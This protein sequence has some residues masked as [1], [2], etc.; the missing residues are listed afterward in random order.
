MAEPTIPNGEE[1]FFPIIYEGNGA[2]Q[3]VGKFVPFTD[4]GTIA[5]SCIFNRAD[6]ATMSRTLETPTNGKIWTF[7]TWWKRGN[8]D[9]DAT[10][11]LG[12]SANNGGGYIGIASNQFYVTDL[13]YSGG[14]AVTLSVV[15]NRTLEDTS[16][17]Y[18]LM[19]AVDTT[20]STANDR[21]KIYIDGDRVTSLDT[22]T[23]PSADLITNWNGGSGT[24]YIGRRGYDT[25]NLLDGYMAET[26]FVD[27][28]ALT[29]STFGVTDTTTGRWIPKTL[30][31]ITYGNSGWRLTYA[32]A[33]N[34]GDD[35]SGNTNDF[36][37]SNLASTDQ[38]TSTPSS[39]YNTFGSFDTGTSATQGNLT[40]STGTTNGDTQCVAQAGFGVATGKWYWEVKITTVGAGMYGWKDD[41]NAGGSQAVNNSS[42]E[43]HSTNNFAG[44]LSTGASGG[45][46]A[47]SWFIDGGYTTEVNYTTVSTNDVLMFAMDLDNGKGYCGKNGTWFNSAN[48]ANGTGQIGGCHYANGVNKFYPMAR[49]VDPNSVGEFNFGQK[50]FAHTAPTGFSA[51]QQDNLPETAKGVSGLVWTKNRDAT[52]S[53]QLYDSSRGKQKVLTSD[54]TTAEATVVDGLQKFLKGGQQIEDDVSVNSEDESYVSWNWTANSGSTSTNDASATGVGTIDSTYQVNS[55]SGFSIVEHTGTGSAGTIK[56]G[57]SVKPAFIMTKSTSNDTGDGFTIYHQN[58]TSAAYYLNLAVSNAEASASTVWNST[59]PT[60]SVF[61]VGT[62]SG[63]NTNTYTYVSYCWAE[64]EGFSK[65]GKYSGNGNADGPFVYTGFRPAFLMIKRTDSSTGG[66]WSIIDN[67]K[68]PANPIGTPLLADSTGAES[69]LS[70]IT[71]DLLSNGFKI[72][73]TL[74]SNNNSSGSYIYMSF[75]E[76]P[77]VGDG[78]NPV[79]AR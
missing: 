55:T 40:V 33:S 72:R 65:F 64:V 41:A 19:V 26:N 14:W 74:N 2:G 6:S 48:P 71:M 45:Y 67:A 79:T 70:A 24:L 4:N 12:Y 52:D 50:S 22:N 53:H 3:R 66:N 54:A 63:T 31:G 5:N 17:W 1:H 77:F 42:N 58:L 51:L 18:H 9:G 57:L 16:K 75:A 78:T 25:T 39:N 44:G 49:R 34:L 13:T 76:H 30:T 59:A 15:S 47:G 43:V 35:T 20:D 7:S 32:D 27:G 68:Y 60:N 23:T 28:T 73:N 37:P 56:H 36:T 69:G 29:P 21:V 11:F 10:K 61:S 62:A 8:L 38:T 46:S